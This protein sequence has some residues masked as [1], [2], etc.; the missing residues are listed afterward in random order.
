MAELFD[1]HF[2]RYLRQK[3]RTGNSRSLHLNVQPQRYLSRLDLTDLNQLEADLPTRFLQQLLHQKQFTFPLSINTRRKL[4]PEEEQHQKRLRRRLEAI[5]IENNDHYLEHG[6]KTFG[7]GF[8]ILLMRDPKQPKRILRAPLLIWSLDISRNLK[9]RAHWRITRKEDFPIVANEL[10]YNFM[11]TKQDVG[12]EALSEDWIE[13]GFLNPK[14][15]AAFCYQQ[16]KQLYP[17]LS[18]NEQNYYETLLE[19]PIRPFPKFQQIETLALKE[20]RLQW[21]GVFGL[22]RSPKQSIIKDL[23]DLLEQAETLEKQAQAPA[24]YPNNRP[25]FHQHTYP[26]V[27]TDPSQQ[28]LLNRLSEGHNIIIQGPPGTGKSQTLT[29][30][31]TNNLANGAR[32][33]VVCEKKTALDVLQQNLEALGLGELSICIEDIYKNR[34]EVVDSVRERSKQKLARPFR[35]SHN[36]R[37][38]L[39]SCSANIAR[40]QRF[41]EKLSQQIALQGNWTNMVGHFLDAQEQ[42]DK[43]LLAP[44]LKAQDFRFE[45]D[46][47]HQVQEALLDGQ[48]LFEALG[49]LQHPFNALS[50][51]IFEQANVNQVETEVRKAIEDLLFSVDGAQRDI[52]AYLYQYERKLET[53]YNMHFAHLNSLAEEV[54]DIINEGFKKSKFYFNKQKGLSNK[55][56]NTFSRFSGKLKAIEKGRADALKAYREMQQRHDRYKVFPFTFIKIKQG[57]FT[58]EELR[59]SARSFEQKLMNWYDNANDEIQHYIQEL[60]IKRLHPHISFQK[61]IQELERNIMLWEKNLDSSKLFRVAF[62]FTGESLRH[63]LDDLE[64]LNKNLENMKSGFEDFRAYHAFR[65]FWQKLNKAQQAALRALATVQPDDWLAA[66]SSWYFHALLSA[67][68]DRQLP[69]EAT[70]SNSLNALRQELQELQKQQ[71]EQTLL[72]WR[73]EQQQEVQGFQRE[74]APLKL[75]SLYNKRG[76]PGQRRHSLRRIVETDFSLFSSF[77]PVL[78][79]SPEVC[80]SILPLQPHLFDVVIFDEASQLRLEDTF[81]ALLRGRFKVVSGDN[82]QMPP[83]DYFRSTALLLQPDEENEDEEEDMVQAAQAHLAGVESLLEYAET[84]GTYEQGLL[85]VHY[86]SRHPHLIDFSNAAFY[87]G[88]LEPMPSRADYRPIRFIPIQGQYDQHCNHAEAKAILDTL[89]K[90]QVDEGGQYPSVGVATFNLYQRNYILEQLRERCVADP[91][92]NDTIQGLLKAGLFVKNLENIQGDERDLLLIS[93]TYG[94]KADGSFRQFFGPIN[95]K[96]GYRLLNVIITRAKSQIEV[97]SSVPESYYMA[98]EQ[99]IEQ[100]GN[101]GKAIFYAYLAYARAISE[102]DEASRQRI[103][104]LLQSHSR[105]SNQYQHSPYAEHPAF[106]QRVQSFLEQHFPQHRIERNYQYAGFRLDLALLDAKGKLW[107]AVEIDASERHESDEAWAWDLFRERHIPQWGLRFV[108][109]WS[110]SWWTRPEQEQQRVLQ[111]LGA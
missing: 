4:S 66:F 22:Y 44:H 34:S 20:P 67:H 19:H 57:E 41:H 21:S 12:L 27:D 49:N 109:V 69:E 54:Q 3:Q 111:L 89:A 37:R 88:T 46:E 38:L 72:Y 48:P 93:T 107:A 5:T 87:G 97:Y 92:Y 18:D 110:Y 65:Y 47:F 45:I 40:L 106:A 13:D 58:Y 29:A 108:R 6:V 42:V 94:P 43:D 83:S 35:I 85:Q 105:R 9:A 61:E 90:L 71:I 23:D 53:H 80:A 55:M 74:K 68:E 77:F 25:T 51:K 7:F 59:D 36:Y 75:A 82:Q 99:A 39:E 70:F 26:S 31:L 16:M 30:M 98:Y 8:P 63:R 56:L 96:R 101:Q 11:L 95:R 103:L 1:S 10:L 104:Q 33:L 50:D 76:A 14:A 2:I 62:N 64:Q 60:S 15:V 28:R 79:L 52:L 78:L 32:T 84:M 73:H 91:A 102:G 17:L 24:N 86:R 100:Q 81:G